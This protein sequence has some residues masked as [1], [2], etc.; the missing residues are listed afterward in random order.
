MSTSTRPAKPFL[1]PQLVDSTTDED[2]DDFQPERPRKTRRNNKESDVKN[3]DDA[4][5]TKSSSN[6]D[7]DCKPQMAKNPLADSDS[8]L[9]EILPEKPESSPQ[10]RTAKNL[11]NI[12]RPLP[13]KSRKNGGKKSVKRPRKGGDSSGGD[14]EDFDPGSDDDEGSEEEADEE[15][16]RSEDLSPEENIS[17]SDF[18]P[19]DEAE[20]GVG[21]GGGNTESHDETINL[22]SDGESPAPK[23]TDTT[24]KGGR[25]NE[26]IQTFDPNSTVGTFFVI[27]YRILFYRNSKSL[28]NFLKK[29]LR[30][31][32]K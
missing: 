20:E 1:V 5:R 22:S 26:N 24:E 32:S 21:G 25:N 12:K 28:K 2:D 27:E 30:N 7:S 3:G 15:S 10:D 19:S 17:D 23:K 16:V 11:R 4:K 13:Q 29:L 6:G 18:I 9:E 14:D 31:K 8:D